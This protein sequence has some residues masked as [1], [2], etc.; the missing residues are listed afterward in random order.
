MPRSNKKK[1]S[2]QQETSS[3]DMDIRKLLGQEK[4]LMISRAIVS[5][6]KH[7]IQLEHGSPNPGVGDCAFEAVIQ[8]NNDRRCF[9]EKFPVVTLFACHLHS[10]EQSCV[11][12]VS[13]KHLP[14]PLRSHIR[15]FGTIFSKKDLK[16]T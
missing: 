14:Q 5:A 15:S 12:R 10:S 3:S 6:V 13:F 16:K 11:C 2:H 4:S 1:H 8:N 9:S 7:G